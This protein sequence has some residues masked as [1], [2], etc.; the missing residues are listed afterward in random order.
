MTWQRG[1]G[2]AEDDVD[3]VVAVVVI[4]E[5]LTAVTEEG[6]PPLD[7]IVV[8]DVLEIVERVCADE[9]RSAE[10]LELI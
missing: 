6:D 1:L 9:V 3:A 8:L 7:A 4:L 5:E 10:T 2:D